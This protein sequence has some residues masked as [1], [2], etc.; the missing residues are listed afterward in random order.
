MAEP[1][2]QTPQAQM[3]VRR[4]GRRALR[5]ALAAIG[6]GLL[7]GAWALASPPGA[8]PD[9]PAHSVRAAAAAVGQWEGL[10]VAP[11][12]RGP[13]RPQ[14][15]AA[16]LNAQAQE[17][18]VP[19]GLV[20]SAPCFAGRVDQPASCASSPAPE[21]A[22]GSVT[23]VTYETTAP[24]GAY[25][26]AGL[27]MRLPQGLLAPVLVGR[28]ALALVCALLLAGA[29]WAAA[30]RGALWPLLGLAL[31]ATPAV[32]FLGASLGTAGVA[33]AAGLCFATALGAFWLG[34]PRRGLEALIAVSGAVLAL[35][36]VAGALS[37]V[38]L[39]AAAV[40]LVQPQRLTR[41]AALL[42]STVV[43][44]AAVAGVALGLGHRPLPP[45]HVDLLEAASAVL[46]AAPTLLAQAVG[47]FGNWDVTLPLVAYAAWGSLVVLGLAAALVLGRWRDRVALV[48]LLAGAA[49][50]AVVG[51]AFVLTPAAWQATASFLLPTLAA[52]PVM[53]A[54]VLHGQRVHPR[55]DALLAGLVV[56]AVQLVA[57]GENARRY[58][59][60]R[61]GPL[62]FTDV[63]QWVPPGGW[64]PWL[65]AA[66]AGGLL[67]VLALMPLSRREWDEEALG[68][69]IVV[70][71]LSVGR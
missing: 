46:A 66:A 65:V 37:L 30:G 16:M 39:A 13:D 18:T 2:A 20:V 35:S 8:P 33:A 34:P 15:Q 57:F 29:A 52:V 31:G 45:G 70:D 38:V 24:P 63:A 6:Y 56:V 61:H 7:L 3:M 5:W 10:S 14:E 32:L 28:L 51:Q 26:V 59:V 21:P 58:A 11:Y 60:G 71:P 9:E 41:P 17:F 22:P 53:A 44:A 43:T 48:L 64:M 4:G 36:S 50:L 62:N 55:T 49:S 23:A 27:A 19:D 67:V 42:A 69:L 68:P 1:Y 54:F 12:L 25:V 40:P 47:V